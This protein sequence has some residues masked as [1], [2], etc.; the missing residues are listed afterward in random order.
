MNIKKFIP[1]VG[2]I[3]KLSKDRGTQVAAVIFGPAGEIRST[4]YNG[5]PRGCDDECEER[6][7]RP[8]KYFWTSHAEENAIANAARVGTPI[9]NCTIITTGLFPCTTCSRM[10]VQSGIKKVI[11]PPSPEGKWADEEKISMEI[12]TEG[13]V[14]IERVAMDI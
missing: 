14:E 6:Y 8:L 1:V 2:E 11:A 3:A 12:L 7:Q 5:F 10:I 13:G 4:G 9:E